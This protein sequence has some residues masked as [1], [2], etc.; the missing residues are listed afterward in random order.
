MPWSLDMKYYLVTGLLSSFSNY[1]II[2]NIMFSR[3]AT[4]PT[5]QNFS[6]TK[7]Q[8]HISNEDSETC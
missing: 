1:T 3:L 7:L 6:D 5:W 8:E 2:Y 4:L